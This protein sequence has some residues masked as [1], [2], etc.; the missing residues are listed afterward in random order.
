MH[1]CYAPHA[2]MLRPLCIFASLVLSAYLENW[3][4]SCGLTSFSNSPLFNAASPATREARAFSTA[5]PLHNFHNSQHT[6]RINLLMSASEVSPRVAESTDVSSHTAAPSNI[7]AEG[8][9]KALDPLVSE[10]SILEKAREMAKPVTL[11]FC[12][13]ILFQFRW[14][15][16]HCHRDSEKILS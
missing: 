4:G 14:P 11:P 2:S 5:Q 8:P 13:Q 15:C 10:P 7:L 6:Q 9:A 3:T 12:F 16:F 1:L